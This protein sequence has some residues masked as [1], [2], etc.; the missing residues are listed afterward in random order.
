LA[1]WEHKSSLEGTFVRFEVREFNTLTLSWTIY[2]EK[3]ITSS[4][5]F[6]LDGM[7]NI[8]FVLAAVIT[9]IMTSH[10]KTSIRCTSNE[11]MPHF[12]ICTSR[13][14]PKVSTNR[15]TSCL[16]NYFL[17]NLQ[18]R[19]LVNSR[20]DVVIENNVFGGNNSDT[21]R[22]ELEDDVVCD[23]NVC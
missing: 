2:E 23:I 11:V 3:T 22:S 15:D 12:N 1:R 10:D 4:H 9:T 16:V 17:F 5:T 13:I 6:S 18:C 19:S 7:G 20:H 21:N 14:R 8:A